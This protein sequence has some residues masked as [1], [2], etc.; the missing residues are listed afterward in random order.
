MWNTQRTS[1]TQPFK[2]GKHLNIHFISYDK[3]MTN[4]HEKRCSIVLGIK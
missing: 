2:K 4:K 1:K 3:P